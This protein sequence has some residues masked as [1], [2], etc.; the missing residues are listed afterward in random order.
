MSP[1]EQGAGLQ[2]SI[3]IWR[4]TALVV[5][6]IIGASIFV[7]PSAIIEAVPNAGAAIGVWFGAGL[8]TLIG[9]LVIAELSSAWPA[10]GGVYVFLGRAFTPAL[11]FLW[12]WAMFWSMHTGIIAAI[13]VV[14]ARYAGTFVP[15]GDT[16]TK[17]VAV[18]AMV[19]L[20]AVNYRGVRHGSVVQ[21]T[22]TLVKVLALV[23][24][25]AVAFALGEPVAAAS[26][27]PTEAVT[28]NGVITALVAGL[29]AYGG[30]HMVSYTA[31][32]TI[33]PTR[34]IPRA[35]MIGTF[36]VTVLYVLANT[37]YLYVLPVDR[38]ASSTRIAAEVAD[39]IFGPVGGRV[40]SALVMLSALG[41]MNG[42]IMAGPRVYQAMAADGL[43][44][45]WVAGVHE[46]FATP[47]RAIAVQ[48]AWASVLIMTG[49]YRSLFTR[50]VYTEWIFFALLAVALFTLRRRPDYAPRYRAWGYPVLPLLFI[51]SSAV[52]VIN[53]LV[54][55]PREASIGLAIVLAG[56]PVYHWWAQRRARETHTAV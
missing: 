21:T 40:V 26:A 27:A 17:A 23:M 45:K 39:A 54:R 8:L 4:A 7:Q 28:G 35:L 43:L 44:F 1:T 42:I 2:R 20:S 41:A 29:F 50:V 52:I 22:L 31:G 11:G 38:V 6:T 14:F 12:G 3:G 34:T 19:L 30:W 10:S 51:V 48:A 16:G 25:I 56:L 49:T 13:A 37:A 47:H 53:Q 32:E 18:A 15:L 55:E 9:A 46:R 36:T 33:E 24:I 5:G